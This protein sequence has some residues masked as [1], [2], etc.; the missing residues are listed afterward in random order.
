[1]RIIA[2]PVC[3]D[4]LGGELTATIVSFGSYTVVGLPGAVPA[5]AKLG[6]CVLSLLKA[7]ERLR[8]FFLDFAAGLRRSRY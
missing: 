7:E 2:L 8:L 3:P 1:M 5:T 6:S 4:A